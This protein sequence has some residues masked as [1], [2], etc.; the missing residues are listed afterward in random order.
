MTPTQAQIEAAIE[1]FCKSAGY[2]MNPA[3]AE[4]SQL[5]R[6]LTSAL[7]AAAQIGKPTTLGG[8][9]EAEQ[10]WLKAHVNAAIE[11]CAQV[12]ETVDDGECGYKHAENIAA[13]IRKLKDEQ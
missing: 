7:T 5:K 3:Y 12:A 1:A 6:D 8:Q 4:G 9:I 2:P 13:A 10:K 11:R